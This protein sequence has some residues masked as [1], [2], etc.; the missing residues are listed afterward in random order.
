MSKKIQPKMN[1]FAMASFL[2]GLLSL[3]E[4]YLAMIN[5]SLAAIII[6]AVFSAAGVVFGVM[7]LQ[8]IKKQRMDGKGLAIAGVVLGGLGVLILFFYIFVWVPEVKKIFAA[9]GLISQ[10]Q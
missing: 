2:V 4:E 6:G 1:G 7:A 8:Q 9:Q 5:L 10:P 3:I